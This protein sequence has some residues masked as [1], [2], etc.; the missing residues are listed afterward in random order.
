MK[1]YLITGVTGFIGSAIAKRVLKELKFFKIKTVDTKE[2]LKKIIEM[3][4]K[5]KLVGSYLWKYD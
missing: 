3:M 5:D 4:K 2:D 1:T